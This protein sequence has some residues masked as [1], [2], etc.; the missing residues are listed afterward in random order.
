MTNL[1]TDGFDWFPSGQSA[2]TRQT[3]FAANDFFSFGGV[4]SNP[5]DVRTGR[6]SFGKAIGFNQTGIFDGNPQTNA[7]V[8]P[9]GGTLAEGWI[10]F[11]YF[12]AA[13]SG[14]SAHPFV[15]F[16][17][18][19]NNAVQVSVTFDRYG[20][21]RVYRG[22]PSNGTLIASSVVGAF[23]EDRWFHG[24]I[25]C[26]CANVGG[27]VEV[28]I[29]TVPKI[30]LTGADT[31]NS[32]NAYFDSAIIGHYRAITAGDDINWAIDDLY[33]NDPS[34]TKLNTWAGNLRVKSQ[35]MVGDG[36]ENAF[37]IGGTAPAATRWQSV[38]NQSIDDTKYV[39]SP[40]VGDKQTFVP[41][42]NL[43]S[44]LVRVVQVR[45][46]LRQDDATQRVARHLLRIGA[47]DYEGSVNHYTN[48]QF[49]FYKTRWDTNPATLVDFTGSEVNGLEA[50]LKVQA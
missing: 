11:A 3:L 1:V 17:D 10:G 44:P 37:T 25:R 20:I 28:R 40:N 14:N 39:Y 36:A 12:R 32:A 41:D 24:E 50:G 15:G 8:V 48:Q 18:A 6:F 47:T 9:V 38:N 2:A 31:K 46:A 27:E 42:P 5:F 34:G 21:M 45:A 49:T 16:F 35:F 4:D 19:L 23:E 30:Q 22:L 26:L 33:I 7:Y 43:N 13:N 29:N